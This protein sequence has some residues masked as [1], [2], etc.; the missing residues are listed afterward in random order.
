MQVTV[1]GLG[2]QRGPEAFQSCLDQSTIVARSGEEAA[3]WIG[4]NATVDHSLDEIFESERVESI[5]SAI[6]RF[7]RSGIQPGHHVVYLVPGAGNLGDRTVEILCDSFDMTIFSGAVPLKRPAGAVQVLDAL[8]LAL[9]E[10][11]Y[12][13]DAGDATVDATRPTLVTNLRG[14]HVKFLACRRLNRFFSSTWDIIDDSS[15]FIEPDKSFSGTTAMSGLEAIVAALRGPGGC[16]W[17]QEQT[18]EQLIPQLQEE[19]EEFQAAL[20]SE[21]VADQ[22]DELGDMLLHVVMIAQIARENGSYTLADVINAISS[23]MIRRHPHVFG[24]MKVDSVEDVYQLWNEIKVQER[25]DRT[26]NEW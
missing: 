9:A 17:D 14:N 18:I 25:T 21:P 20:M 2:G 4:R 19:I 10:S 11:K 22:F 15:V 8:D 23:K 5:P 3:R 26:R 1:I 6:D 16:P 24:D 7:F 12:P 13:F